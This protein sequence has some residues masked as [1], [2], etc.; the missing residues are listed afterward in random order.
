MLGEKDKF[1]YI[2]ILEA[3]SIKQVEMKDKLKKEYLIG[4]QKAPQ[5][6]SIKQKPYEMN[7]YLAYTLVRYSGVFLER[8]REELK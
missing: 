3:D 1:R 6:K 4:K 8:T 7:K 5:D 2:D